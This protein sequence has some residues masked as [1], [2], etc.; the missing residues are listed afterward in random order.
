MTR[1]SLL[2]RPPSSSSSS[3]PP[4]SPPLRLLPR[5]SPPP[6]RRR[7]TRRIASAPCTTKSPNNNDVPSSSSTDEASRRMRRRRRRRNSWTGYRTVSSW[8]RRVRR[9]V[10]GGHAAL[11]T[12]RGLGLGRVRFPR[13]VRCPVRRRGRERFGDQRQIGGTV[14]N[15]NV[16]LNQSSP[17]S[18]AGRF[19]PAPTVGRRRRRPSARRA[20]PPIERAGAPAPTKR[21]AEGR[22]RSRDDD[23]LAAATTTREEGEDGLGDNGAAAVR[24]GDEDEVVVPA[25]PRD[26]PSDGRFRARKRSPSGER[27]DSSSS[28]ARGA[29][30]NGGDAARVRRAEE[31]APETTPETPPI[32]ANAASEGEG[33]PSPK[34]ATA[35]ASRGAAPGW[36]IVV[37]STARSSRSRRA[38]EVSAASGAGRRGVDDREGEARSAERREPAGAGEPRGGAEDALVRRV[39]YRVS[40]RREEATR[41]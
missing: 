37:R 15:V 23:T 30:G 17:G 6:R 22:H 38:K 20:P 13:S 29:R 16:A 40:V 11:R 33:S 10:R 32:A 12:R 41:S 18:N 36:S 31:K 21:R 8:N 28:A 34:A 5:P 24:V 7:C 27:D 9:C 2:R 26:S 4:L 19:P 1:R 14:V 25:E 35:T 39:D 3:S